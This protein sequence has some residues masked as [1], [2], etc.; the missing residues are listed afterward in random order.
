MPKKT[1]ASRCQAPNAIC[2]DS[3]QSRDSPDFES[4]AAKARELGPSDL[5][6]LK[7]QSHC[8]RQTKHS[9]IQPR[10]NPSLQASCRRMP[11]RSYQS[12]HPALARS[13]CW[14][15]RKWGAVV[16]LQEPHGALQ[17][18]SWGMV[19]VIQAH[20]KHTGAMH[21]TSSHLCLVQPARFLNSR[22]RIRGARA[23]DCPAAQPHAGSGV[24]LGPL[25]GT[26]PAPDATCLSE[27]NE[28]SAP[29]ALTL[30]F[31]SQARRP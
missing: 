12:T 6:E 3:C 14:A 19:A 30:A 10:R 29:R 15:A 21:P 1:Y 27:H 22:I 2:S 5:S 26:S 24:G 23:S 13:V 4:N 28:N 17:P 7:R 20:A 11:K 8:R 18:A 16:T 9:T 25:S 31:D